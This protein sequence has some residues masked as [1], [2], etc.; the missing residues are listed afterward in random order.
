MCIRDRPR[1]AVAEY[2]SLMG[3]DASVTIRYDPAFVMRQVE[4]V[5][6]GYFGASLT[7][8]TRSM[9]RR[10]MRLVT[11]DFRGVNAFFL[12]EDLA[13]QIPAVEPA[14]VFRMLEKHQNM[15]DQGYDLVRICE[16]RGLE[17]VSY[18]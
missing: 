17:L 7:A 18:E 3:P 1:I 16:E 2:N 15:V 14:Q 5:D 8:L 10:G 6:G 13:P 11:T 4:G 9:A 12:R